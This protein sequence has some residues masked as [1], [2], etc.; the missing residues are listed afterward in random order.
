MVAGVCG[1]CLRSLEQI[2]VVD[3]DDYSAAA[4]GEIEMIALAVRCITVYDAATE[5]P[6]S[7][8]SMCCKTDGSVQRGQ[9]RLCNR[10]RWLSSPTLSTPTASRP[11]P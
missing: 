9:F 8:P 10:S 11:F 2:D 7:V 5:A 4:K 3:L 6:P 1:E